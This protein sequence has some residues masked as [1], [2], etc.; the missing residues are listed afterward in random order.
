MPE[1]NT[2]ELDYWASAFMG[3]AESVGLE[4]RLTTSQLE[5]VAKYLIRWRNQE[6]KVRKFLEDSTNLRKRQMAEAQG[7]VKEMMGA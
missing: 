3:A 6:D 1:S 7:V 4:V 5:A 2:Q